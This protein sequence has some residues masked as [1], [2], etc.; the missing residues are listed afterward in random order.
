MQGGQ[1]ETCVLYRKLI[2]VLNCAYKLG[3]CQFAILGFCVLGVMEFE[4]IL[5]W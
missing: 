3:E 5:F 4:L 1:L 2:L